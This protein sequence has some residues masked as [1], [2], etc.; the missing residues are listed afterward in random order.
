[1]NL[2]ARKLQS[3]QWES[4]RGVSSALIEGRAITHFENAEKTSNAVKILELK[5]RMKSK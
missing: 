1:M 5:R 3:S 2:A 4:E